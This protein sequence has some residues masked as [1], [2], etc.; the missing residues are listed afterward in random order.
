M[1]SNT[2]W[3]QHARVSFSIAIATYMVLK[4]ISCYYELLNQIFSVFM[5]FIYFKYLLGCNCVLENVANI[6]SANLIFAV[7]NP[8]DHGNMN[9]E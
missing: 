8:T 6:Y 4:Q 7:K 5:P 9:L 2:T 3:K 1:S